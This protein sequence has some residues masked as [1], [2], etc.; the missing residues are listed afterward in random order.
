MN[1]ADRA[2]KGRIR[3]QGREGKQEKEK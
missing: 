2:R 3:K 1:T